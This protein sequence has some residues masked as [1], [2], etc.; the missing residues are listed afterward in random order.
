[1][2]QIGINLR[3]TLK[4]KISPSKT[5]ASDRAQYTILG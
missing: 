4:Q 2:R 3:N 1:M 5:K